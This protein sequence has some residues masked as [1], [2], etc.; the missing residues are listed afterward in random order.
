MSFLLFWATAVKPVEKTRLL[1]QPLGTGYGIIP[2]LLLFCTCLVKL[3]PPCGYANG[4]A[5]DS[6]LRYNDRA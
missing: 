1:L 3:M 2:Q 6:L 5:N 4:I